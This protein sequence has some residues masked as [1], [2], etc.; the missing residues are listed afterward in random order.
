[1]L[2]G[3]VHVRIIE[4][5]AIKDFYLSEALLKQLAPY[6]AEICNERETPGTIVEITDVHIETFIIFATWLNTKNGPYVFGPL[7]KNPISGYYWTAGMPL[8]ELYVFT[9]EYEIP[10][11]A[12][13]ALRRFRSLLY[14]KG[15]KDNVPRCFAADVEEL[16]TIKEI[17][18]AFGNT[19]ANSPLRSMLVGAFCDADEDAD[20][21]LM[22][23]DR[24]FLVEVTMQM[25]KKMILGRV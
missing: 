6:F 17:N 13:D 18:Y 19:D 23:A 21:E 14:H 20:Y 22:T 5:K 4:D 7:H 24:E 16:P 8:I 15:G 10:K 3:V 12:E 2:V 1:M 9:C 25:Q 11:V